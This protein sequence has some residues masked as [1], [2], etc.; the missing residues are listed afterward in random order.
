M[1]R[2]YKK[3]P[4]YT[5]YSRKTTK[6]WKR[7][8]NHKVRRENN[9]PN[10]KAYR[11]VYNSWKIHDYVT[12]WTKTEAIAWYNKVTSDSWPYNWWIEKYSTLDAYLNEYWE[13]DFHRK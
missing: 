12:R 13:H 5:D 11:K 1:S 4:V 7:Q 6:Y 8:A 10:G 9:I 2:S 3:E